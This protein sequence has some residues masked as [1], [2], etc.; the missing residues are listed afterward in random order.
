[1]NAESGFTRIYIP[2]VGL[3]AGFAALV[4]EST[5]TTLLPPFATD[6]VVADTWIVCAMFAWFAAG[7]LYFGRKAAGL[8]SHLRLLAYTL[9]GTGISAILVSQVFPA[10]ETAVRT[11][12]ADYPQPSAAAS[13]MGAAL[14]SAV[15]FVPF[16]LLGGIAVF[17]LEMGETGGTRSGEAGMFFPFAFAGGAAAVLTSTFGMVPA[18]GHRRTLIITAV[19]VAAVGLMALLRREQSRDMRLRDPNVTSSDRGWRAGAGY[20]A[21]ALFVIGAVASSILWAR[22]V[23][24]TTGRSGYAWALLTGVYLASMALGAAIGQR[25]VRSSPRTSLFSLIAAL[26]GLVLLAL[27]HLASGLPL[28]FTHVARWT[29]SAGQGMLGAGLTVSAVTMLLPGIL[30]G[31]SLAVLFAAGP[32][33]RRTAFHPVAASACAGSLLAFVMTRFIPT[34]NF[35]FRTALASIPWLC[36]AGGAYFAVA[37]RPKS[38]GRLAAY[39][40]AV[41]IAIM[42][43]AALPQWDRHMIT[44]SVLVR[45][46]EAARIANLREVVHSAD[47]IFYEETPAGIVALARTPDRIS[48]KANGIRIASMPEGMT[49]QILTGHIAL[50]MHAQPGRVLLLGISNGVTLRA[51]AAH[52][53]NEIVCVEPM[54]SL[55]TAAG[56]VAHY[57]GNVLADRRVSVHVGDAA[58]YLMSAGNFD[59]IIVE[60]PSYQGSRAS[61]ILTVDFAELVRS[62]L[63]PDGIAC[64]RLSMAGL[65][66]EAFKSIASGF[67]SLFPSVSVWWAAPD[68]VVLLGSM[69]PTPAGIEVTAARLADRGIADDLN[70]TG[71]G[72]AIGLLSWY[73]MDRDRLMQF[74][75]DSPLSTRDKNLV[76]PEHLKGQVPPDQL[77]TLRILHG[78]GDQLIALTAG[79]GADSARFEEI[80][81]TIGRCMRARLRYLEA[82]ES[83]NA[84]LLAKAISLLRDA[85]QL[86]PNN[87]TYRIHLADHLLRYSQAYAAA[88]RIEEA[89]DAA[90]RSI[91][92]YPSGHRGFYQLGSLE[93]DRRP[94][95]SIALLGKAIELNPHY[96]P[97]YLLKARTEMV[98]GDAE[99]AS[100]TLGAALSVEP[101]NLTAHHLR[102]LSFIERDMLDEAR[103]EIDRVTEAEPDNVEALDALAYTWLIEGDLDRAEQLYRT[104]L[105]RRPEHLTALNNYGTILAEKG[106]FEGAVRTWTKALSLD[107]GNRDIIDNIEEARQKMRR[108]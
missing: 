34:G 23:T 22:L 49:P 13:L 90:R 33:G 86:C 72:D 44:G 16:F 7:G 43:V 19:A 48:L 70:R 74:V 98:S 15:V 31:C 17:C 45:P 83:I 78:A 35:G 107:P 58:N 36:L 64:Y 10:V 57:N 27:G 99:E 55:V 100:R 101:L 84:G 82:L 29:G 37:G 80:H 38:T 56:L 77:M 40:A 1:L 25:A 47:M 63:A 85:S 106:D 104:V 8:S 21:Y 66:Q 93:A 2:L 68:Q 94:A 30:L 87:G 62:A 3:A 91:E 89:I 102:A 24:E 60:H 9:I 76:A 69:A 67:A 75:G 28:V 18:L 65:P 108:R 51:A 32:R 41:L 96:M 26:T 73:M 103:A 88:G 97:A 92:A 54:A 61:D 14:A 4:F 79:A 59:V 50:L 12:A 71:F 42:L 11:V 95:V 46:Q 20:F 53:V 5:W 39:A 105:K 6:P 81:S 52:P